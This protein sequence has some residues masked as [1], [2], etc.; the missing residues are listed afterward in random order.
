[1]LEK[2]P[3]G[4]GFKLPESFPGSDCGQ[5]F[6][7]ISKTVNGFV[8]HFAAAAAVQLHQKNAGIVQFSSQQIFD[9]RQ[10]KFSIAK[11]LFLAT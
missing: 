7:Q 2:N 1:M 3:G 8:N 9:D 4:C 10:F 6:E 11:A 5:R